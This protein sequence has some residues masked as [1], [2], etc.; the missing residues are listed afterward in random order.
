[1]QFA[2]GGL[3]TARGIASKALGAVGV[4]RLLSSKANAA[5]NAEYL[6]TPASGELLDDI[7]RRGRAAA[8]PRHP[9]L[10]RKDWIPTTDLV[11]NTAAR[12]AGALSG[13][14]AAP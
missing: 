3:T 1:M 5:K 10:L 4:D 8:E 11:K 12:E 14:R 6:L 13:R 7:L 2:S 9:A